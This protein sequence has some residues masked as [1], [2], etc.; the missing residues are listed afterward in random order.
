MNASARPSRSRPRQTGRRCGCCSAAGHPAVGPYR[1]A[2]N[3]DGIPLL[4]LEVDDVHAEHA[5]LKAAGVRF[6]APP[7]NVGEVDM[8]IF[9]DTV[10]NLVQIMSP[11][12]PA[13]P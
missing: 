11:A 10:G 5:R 7:M 13:S 3:A 2:L 6:T 12:A 1:A 8:A 4:Q 9:D